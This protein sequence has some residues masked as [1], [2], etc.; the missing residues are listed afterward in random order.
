[1]RRT[2]RH[3]TEPEQDAEPNGT[4]GGSEVGAFSCVFNGAGE[5]GDVLDR[6]VWSKR[7]SF[8]KLSELAY[9]G[10]ANPNLNQPLKPQ[11]SWKASAICFTF[12]QVN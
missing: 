9:V 8:K 3:G 11:L 6:R 5:V 4:P 2:A 10:L 1:M 7:P 12:K